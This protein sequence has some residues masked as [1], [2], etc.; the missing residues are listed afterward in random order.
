MT[1]PRSR[2]LAIACVVLAA[3]AAPSWVPYRTR[4]ATRSKDPPALVVPMQA[5]SGAFGAYAYSYV[6]HYEE[7]G[8]GTALLAAAFDADHVFVVGEGGVVLARGDNGNWTHEPSGTTA[9]LRGLVH[10]PGPSATLL[11]VGDHGTVVR[12]G[13]AGTWH[14]EPSGTEQDLNDVRVVDQRV[15]AIG[16]NRLTLERQPSGTWVTVPATTRALVPHTEARMK[17]ESDWTD[18][19]TVGVVGALTVATAP[20]PTRTYRV[21]RQGALQAIASAHGDVFAVGAMGTIL[22]LHA[23]GLRVGTIDVQAL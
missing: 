22:H 12:R 9:T 21:P 17:W 23:E 4:F 15:L 11:A 14:T 20:G 5:R 8:V 7:S 10:V 1:V 2:T 16:V 6:G 19:F 18:V 3:C 13:E